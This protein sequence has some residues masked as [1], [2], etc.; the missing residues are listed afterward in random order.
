MLEKCVN[1]VYCDD[2]TMIASQKHCLATFQ[3][4]ALICEQARKPVPTF[5]SRIR[6]CI[7]PK[8]RIRRLHDR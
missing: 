8:N 4:S 1:D 7:W 2:R 3:K 6:F 5:F